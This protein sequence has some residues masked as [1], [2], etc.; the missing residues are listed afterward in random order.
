[1][2]HARKIGPSQMSDLPQLLESGFEIGRRF[3][4]GVVI[5]HIEGLAVQINAQVFHVIHKTTS[6][7][8][9]QAMVRIQ[10]VATKR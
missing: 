9:V 5:R 6:P 10:F 2:Q 4:L 7:R 1:M 8:S 3:G